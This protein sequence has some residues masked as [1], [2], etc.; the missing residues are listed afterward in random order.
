MLSR[1]GVVL[2]ATVLLAG[3]LPGELLSPA[4]TFAEEVL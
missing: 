2:V 4:A 1:K 3:G